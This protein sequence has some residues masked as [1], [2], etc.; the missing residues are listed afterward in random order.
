[1]Y[2]D[3][4]FK[5]RSVDAVKRDI[6]TAHK[7]YH[8]RVETVFIGD[9]DSLVMQ[10]EPLCRILKYLGTVFPSKTRVTSYARAGTLKRRSLDNLKRLRE[11]GLTR[12]HIGLESGSDAILKNIRK[13]ASR[14]TMIK[15]CRK[16]KKAGFQISLYVL[17][18]IGGEE[19]W[20]EHA[21]ETA[22]VINE[23]GPDFIRVRTLTPQPGTDVYRWMEEGTFIMPS[24]ETV[25]KEQ[26]KLINRITTS[27]EYLSDHVSNYAPVNGQIPEDK[28]AMLS[29][30]SD[31]LQHLS[32]NE[33]FRQRLANM[34]HL[35]R[36]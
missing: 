7:L 11:A 8:D 10:T 30:I 5:I 19:M 28:E 4:P 13:G 9:S 23:I 31:T 12:L 1:M 25:L 3:V 15:G 2:R 27:T 6:D 33:N 24:P 20:R 34:Q 29:I 18:G 36:L 17:A 26:E 22:E 35:R 14:E 32:E 16:A 21:E